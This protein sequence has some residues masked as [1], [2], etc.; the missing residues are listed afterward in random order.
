[1]KKLFL[2][3]FIFLF[4][5][6]SAFGQNFEDGK[7]R[8]YSMKITVD[9]TEVTYA[10]G[11]ALFLDYDKLSK[12]EEDI[13]LT[14]SEY[15]FAADMGDVRVSSDAGGETQM[16]CDPVWYT[17][18]AIVANGDCEIWVPITGSTTTD[19][20]F[21]LWWG[22]SAGGTGSQPAADS[23]YGSEAV[24]ANDL[25]VYHMEEL[26]TTT[27][28]DST[29]NGYTGTKKASD[30]PIKTA[31]GYIG[32]C[33]YFNYRNFIT[34]TMTSTEQDYT[35]NMW[36][37]STA[38]NDYAQIV[39]SP[40]VRMC[41]NGPT[42]G[43]FGFLTIDGWTTFT[44]STASAVSWEH[45][46]F[47]FDATAGTAKVYVNGS[48]DGDTETYT[49]TNWSTN[50]TFGA[51]SGLCPRMYLDEFQFTESAKSATQIATEYAMYS[52]DFATATAPVLSEFGYK[53]SSAGG[54]INGGTFGGITSTSIR[55]NSGVGGKDYFVAANGDG[56]SDGHS[57]TDAIYPFG[58]LTQ[59]N[60]KGLDIVYFCGSVN[61][62]MQP[63]QSG[64]DISHP[65]IYSSNH[66][67]QSGAISGLRTIDNSDWV[68][69]SGDL[70]RVY[71]PS[72]VD[73]VFG[74][75][76]GSP[77]VGEKWIDTD[78]SGPNAVEWDG[79]DWLD[80][81]WFYG[82][83]RIYVDGVETDP[84]QTAIT[85]VVYPGLTSFNDATD[86]ARA[87]ADWF[88][89][90]I[91][92]YHTC[93]WLVE[94]KIITSSTAAGVISYNAFNNVPGDYGGGIFKH[95][96]GCINEIDDDYEWG[97]KDDYLYM[98]LPST[99]GQ[100]VEYIADCYGIW[101]QETDNITFD[102]LTIGNTN[103]AN[104]FS[105]M[106]DNIDITNNTCRKASPK[107]AWWGAAIQAL[108]DSRTGSMCMWDGTYALPG[109]VNIN[110]SGNVVSDCI[111]GSGI[112]VGRYA[113][114]EVDDNEITDICIT[115]RIRSRGNGIYV[116][117]ADL[118]SVS[119]N[120]T[121]NTGYSGI[122]VAFRAD[123]IEYNVIDYFMQS[124]SD[125]GG[126]YGAGAGCVDEEIRYNTVMN[127]GD[128]ASIRGI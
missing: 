23:T 85:S 81:D 125:G 95:I 30:S 122:Q 20:D 110:V 101:I 49:G 86:L 54:V 51:D 1:M 109:N 65:I 107:Q 33:Q 43:E 62:D 67:V 37:K 119:Y 75:T 13:F 3:P 11:I 12:G 79:T 58:S 44:G 89:G 84:V 100:S 55:Q 2:F 66:P 123:I 46:S 27:I 108:G 6:V 61:G 115:G 91:F 28:G 112:T 17:P 16:A 127:A 72:D 87:A 111:M 60:L 103:E 24:W 68:L 93:N 126:I 64:D 116:L 31:A 36:I 118:E 96:E 117:S 73:Y 63:T 14:G 104:I 57:Y 18:A 47:V 22:M 106:S 120:K 56:T 105:Y 42:A 124:V 53:T 90:A 99:T 4:M 71:M 70:Y 52:A 35:A 128:G 69:V 45:L 97:W 92:V 29:A 80:C 8:K 76:P 39:Y 9:H 7:D 114:G 113:G 83:T 59:S 25:C 74:T 32:T 26:T 10:G 88:T 34:S 48:Q 38:S 77:S 15:A 19:V 102:N 21:Y 40:F 98:Q 82:P 94:S 78:L 50:T 41:W 5:S 121:T